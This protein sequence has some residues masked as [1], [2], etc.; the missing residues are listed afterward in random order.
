M[1]NLPCYFVIAAYLFSSGLAVAADETIP[2]PDEAKAA[3][4]TWL[5]LVDDGKYAD[6]WKEASSFLKGMVTEEKWAG[7]LNQSREPLGSVNK[8]E[9]KTADFSHDVP[10]AP[11]GDYW[12]IQF[13]TDFD[14]NAVIEVI[15][16][17]FDKDGKWRVAGYAIKSAS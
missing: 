10:R 14:G 5:K 6:S 7:A 4:L 12:V 15:T 9:L 13:L 8:R 16:V 3:A 17:M 2:S 1:R 11:K